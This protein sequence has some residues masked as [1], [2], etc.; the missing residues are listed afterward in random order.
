MIDP[1]EIDPIEQEIFHRGKSME[2]R[3][4]PEVLDQ[5]EEVE[6]MLEERVR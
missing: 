6:G 3:K 5:W 4:D 2:T 1:T